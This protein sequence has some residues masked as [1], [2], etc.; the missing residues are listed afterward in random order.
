MIAMKTHSK[1][2][3]LNP[4]SGLGVCAG[5]A[6]LAGFT[7]IE[8]MISAAL[9]SLILTAAY[10]C[11]SAC[12]ASQR[13]L[14]PRLDAVQRARVAL[15]LMSADLRAACPLDPDLEFLGTPRNLGESPADDVDFATH[16]YAPRQD[17]EGDFCE[18]S[19]FVARSTARGQ[20]GLWRRRNPTLALDPLEGGV[21]EELASGVLGLQLEYFDGFDWYD[22]WGDSTGKA[23]TSNKEQPNLTGMP[24]AVRITLWLNA[25]PQAKREAEQLQ[26]AQAPEPESSDEGNNGAV[27]TNNVMP[28]KFQTVVRLNLAQ[29]SRPAA[30]S[31][32]QNQTD[33]TTGGSP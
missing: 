20:L 9:L 33:T 27:P 13:D 26:A 23:R 1:P 24:E 25:S 4:C 22:S 29:V 5:K 18:E 6:D 28:L 32:D 17:R 12:V 10:L 31:S 30:G 11:L 21:K 19:F 8:L 14:E 16:N 3:P 15:A 7:M 2:R